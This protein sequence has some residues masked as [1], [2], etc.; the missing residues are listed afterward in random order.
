[1]STAV[2]IIIVVLAALVAL[3]V[4]QRRFEIVHS[5][6]MEAEP[7]AVWALISDLAKWPEWS[8][9]DKHEPDSKTELS[10]QTNIEGSWSSWDGTYIGA[11]KMTTVKLGQDSIELKLEFFRPRFSPCLVG[12]SMERLGDKRCKVT[13]DMR[14]SMPLLVSLFVLKRMRAQILRDYSLGLGYLERLVDPKADAALLSFEFPADVSGFHFIGKRHRCSVPAIGP[15]M[16][17]HLPKMSAFLESNGV[18]PANTPRTIWNKRHFFGDE[19][20]FTCAIPISEEDAGRLKDKVADA[21]F[22]VGGYDGGGGFVQ[23]TLLG[24]YEHLSQAWFTAFD[25]MKMRRLKFDWRRSPLEIYDND[26]RSTDGRD[27]KTR[28]LIATR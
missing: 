12:L 8:P 27:L 16:E 2:W 21:G 13:W 1:M 4:I 28:I 3:F 14:G 18:Q 15:W 17:E 20:T 22:L 5:S 6:E 10:E 9:W 7:D 23:T 11:G 26:P 25:H 24:A 19:F